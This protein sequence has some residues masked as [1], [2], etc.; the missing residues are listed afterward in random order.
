MK[1]RTV[2]LDPVPHGSEFLIHQSPQIDV[3]PTLL[4]DEAV[5]FRERRN[6]AFQLGAIFLDGAGLGQANEFWMSVRRLFDR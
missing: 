4:G 3:V 5:G 6:P 1:V 2:E